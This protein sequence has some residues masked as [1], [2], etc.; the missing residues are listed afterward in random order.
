MALWHTP[1][2]EAKILAQQ[3]IKARVEPADVAAMVSFLASDD[4]RY[5]TNHSYWVDAGYR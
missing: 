1:D 2:E 4:A 5:C 3:C